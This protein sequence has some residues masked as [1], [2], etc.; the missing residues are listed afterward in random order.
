M[1]NYGNNPYEV[2]TLTTSFTTRLDLLLQQMVSKLRGSV[3]SAQYVGKAASPVQQIGVLNYTQPAGRYSPLVPQIPKFT[4][5][6]VFPNDRDLTVLVDNFDELRTIVDPKGGISQAAAAAANRYF[7]DLI[8]NAAN[9]TATTGVDPSNFSTESFNSTASTSGGALVADTFGASAST[10]LTYPKLV[11]AW[12]VYRHAQVDLEAERPVLVIASQQE[13]D[14]KKQ[15]EFISK[16]YG[17]S[18][19]VDNGLVTML[20][21]F[22]CIMSERLNSSSSTTLR[23]CL[24]WVRSGMHL[25]IWKDVQTRITE[26]V[27]LTSIPWQL[28]SMISA[29]ATRLQQFKVLQINAADTSGFDPT[30]P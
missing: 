16:E 5:R 10:G 9:G 29:G 3:D 15:Q 4:R 22:E 18:I 30:A 2:E 24:S 13:S 7:D 17:G 20:A 8:I 11:E 1:A 25:G 26:R 6:W 28:Y 14:A 12:R 21:G 27:D 23:N 19:S